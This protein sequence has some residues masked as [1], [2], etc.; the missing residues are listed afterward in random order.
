MSLTIDTLLRD[1]VGAAHVFCLFIMHGLFIV[2]HPQW[3]GVHFMTLT[4]DFKTN[5]IFSNYHELRQ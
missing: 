5:V 3:V 2:M 4:N 1:S